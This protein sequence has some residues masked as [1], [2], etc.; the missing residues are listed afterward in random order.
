LI[1]AKRLV[2]VLEDWAPR[3][4]GFYLYH[5]S[6]RQVPPALQALIGFLRA[7]RSRAGSAG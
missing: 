6:R 7:N 2:P 3:I 1:A 5:S 4:S